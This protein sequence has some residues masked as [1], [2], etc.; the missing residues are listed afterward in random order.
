[1]RQSLA[2][3]AFA[4]GA[5]A[6]S[7]AWAETTWTGNT[8]PAGAHYANGSSEPV[9]TVDQSTLT[10]SCTGTAISGV[11]NTDAAVLLLVS[12]SGTVTC[13]N[14]GNNTV[15]VKTQFT[16]SSGSDG[17]TRVRN[18][19][20]T[21]APISSTGP[22]TQNF[23]SRA[24]CPNGN[25]TKALVDGSAVITSFTYTLTFDGYTDPVIVITGP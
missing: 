13:T 7:M 19:T 9:C 3:P 25:W 4:I 24:S 6:L 11:G 17:D 1:M 8:A 12:Y 18:G 15:E 22:S 23:L 14:K 2:I 21:V 20:L 10:V 5:L 16:T